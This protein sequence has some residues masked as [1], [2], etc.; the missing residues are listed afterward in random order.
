MAERFLTKERIERF[1]EDKTIWLS[2]FWDPFIE[3]NVILRQNLSRLRLELLITFYHVGL[4][5][6][7]SKNRNTVKH[8]FTT[9]LE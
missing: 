5:I 3:I 4:G 9:T 6:M 1:D 2:L 7:R 8:N